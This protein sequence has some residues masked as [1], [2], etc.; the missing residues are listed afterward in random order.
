M[1]RLLFARLAG[2]FRLGSSLFVARQKGWPV[3]PSGVT[4]GRSTTVQGNVQ[5]APT[6]PS[7]VAAFMTANR[8]TP[9]ITTSI[10]FPLGKGS[11]GAQ[12]QQQQGF[13]LAVVHYWTVVT[14][15]GVG[16]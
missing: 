1:F 3:G 13:A 14:V 9:Y 6:P 7:R 10:D 2:S 16:R 15:D 8:K 12:G 4:F 5:S 11:T